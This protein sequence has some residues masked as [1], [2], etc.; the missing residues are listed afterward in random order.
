IAFLLFMLVQTAIAQEKPPIPITV[1]VNTSQ[2]LN[3]GSFT[4]GVTGGTVSVDYNSTRTSTG[5][6]FE[7]NMGA[8]PSAALFDVTANP[9]TIIQISAPT[10]IPLTGSNGGV[11][12]LDINSFSTGQLFISTATPPNVNSVYV[13]G[14][15]TI[16][17]NTNNL[18]G[19]YNGNFTL[20]FI[21]Q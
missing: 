7:L 9:G 14:T 1:E 3:F 19:Q 2:N 4:V 15:L 11:I 16:P 21:H 17:A 10:N 6:V 12:Y 18:P 5:D 13:G 20:T 8:S